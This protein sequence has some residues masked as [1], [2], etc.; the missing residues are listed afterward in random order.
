MVPANREIFSKHQDRFGVEEI[1]DLRDLLDE[2]LTSLDEN[3]HSTLS[4]LPYAHT[5]FSDGRPI[6]ALYRRVYGDAR[7]SAALS[8]EAAFEADFSLLDQPADDVRRGKMPITRAMM[9]IWK[10]VIAERPSNSLDG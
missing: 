6:P 3:G 5:C 9:Q 4:L 10:E 8:R 2:Y 7:P 1:G